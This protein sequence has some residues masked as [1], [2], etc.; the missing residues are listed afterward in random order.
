M[1]ARF[2][3][4]EERVAALEGSG[5]ARSLRP[6]FPTGPTTAELEGREIQVF[7]SNDYLGLA[8]ELRSSW[9]GR[10]AGSSRLIA[11]DR[12]AHH[13]LEEKLE[14]LFCGP[15]LV[16]P[17]GYHANLAL[18]ST[19][20]E[21]G[22]VVASDALNHA[23][24]IDGLRLSKA[25]RRV[26]PHADPAAIPQDST[27]VVVEG[28]YSMDGDQLPLSEYKRRDRW[29]VVDEA[30]AVGC[31][32]PKGRGA[33]YEQ[34]LVPD[35]VV[36]TLGKAYGAAGAFVIVPWELKQL[37]ISKG[38]SFVYTTGLAEAAARAALV[39]VERADQ[40]RRERL[41]SRVQRF[42]A[43]LADLGRF[44]P[45]KDHIVPL[46]L[47]PATMAAAQALLEEGFFVP[48][49]RAP[50]VARGQ[51]RLRFSLSAAHSDA[52]IDALLAAIDRVIR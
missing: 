33:S 24:I 21:D 23:S 35:V 41:A 40:G 22:D 1:R 14:E 13:A 27:A 34:G 2:K 6:L 49:I 11:G 51:E 45:G 25:T 48:G 18:M 15:A 44:P 42:R 31:I 17:S 19:L 20:F 43:G 37:L 5:L 12:N 10:G 50:T 52:Q 4:L 46:V 7:S 39:G 29:L 30:H 9:R 26:I 3:R 36:G 38:R 32:G 28:L 16:F 8:W 47:G